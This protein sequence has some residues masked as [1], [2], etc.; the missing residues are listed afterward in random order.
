V[1]PELFAP[2]KRW[3]SEERAAPLSIAGEIKAAGGLTFSALDVGWHVRNGYPQIASIIGGGMQSWSGE[4][5]SVDTALN[6]SAVWA[7]YRVISESVGSTPAVMMQRKGVNTQVAKHPMSDSIRYEPNCEIT[8]QEYRESQTGHCVL[9]GDAFSRIIRRSGTDVAMELDPLLPSQVDI[10][11]EKGGRKRLVYIVKTSEGEQEKTYT[12]ERGK[13]QDILHV[14][15]I[16]WN[17]IRGKSYIDEP[18]HSSALPITDSRR[19]RRIC[20]GGP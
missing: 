9:G 16:G 6:L 7:C 17:G 13:A 5:I 14:R 19:R 18:A 10:D 11:R 20:L 4:D 15:G 8:S 12:V 3:F 1:F 2:V